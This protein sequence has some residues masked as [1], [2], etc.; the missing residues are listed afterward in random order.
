MTE[1]REE[2]KGK[3]ALAP[4][5]DNYHSYLFMARL[6]GS[7]ALAALDDAYR[8]AVTAYA[9]MLGYGLY[10]E[11]DLDEPRA[12]ELLRHFN[13]ELRP[14]LDRIMLYL[15]YS[16]DIVAVA[17]E[18]LRRLKQGRQI[19]DIVNKLG[20]VEDVAKIVEAIE[21][22]KG[23]D[24]TIQFLLSG[25]VDERRLEVARKVA[26]TARLVGQIV[27][28][29][30]ASLKRLG[31]GVEP[32]GYSRMR[33]V[34]ELAKL[35]PLSYLLLTTDAGI[36]MLASEELTSL[37]TYAIGSRGRERPSSLGIVLDVSGSMAGTEIVYAAGIAIALFTIFKP[38]K[39][40]LALFS[41]EIH[42]VPDARSL[43]EV[44]L[45][46]RPGGGTNIARA[47]EHVCR[48]WS[49]VDRIVLISD[50]RDRPPQQQQSCNV[51][52]VIVTQDG[53]EQ[54]GWRSI[55]TA[56]LI[57]WKDGKLVVEIK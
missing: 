13:T 39:K 1:R 44:L 37:K 14:W 45:T 41:S 31:P 50:G 16:S 3:Y 24:Y 53:W 25:S 35:H 28:R 27:S 5:F 20:Y 23:R 29:R 12:R 7:D 55:P 40:R 4:A 21:G 11:G 32:A 8:L 6:L 30:I 47:V 18:I 49:D 34:D 19:G 42:E 43:I 36:R 2:Y 15:L 22:A 9:Y 56:W 46:V 54:Y 57:T 48:H 33:D 26:A 17:R 52:Y 38:Q 51:S 10:S